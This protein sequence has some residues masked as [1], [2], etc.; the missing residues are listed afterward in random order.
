M[1]KKVSGEKVIKDIR[2]RTPTKY[3]SDSTSPENG[4]SCSHSGA[5]TFFT[6]SKYLFMIFRFKPVN[7]AIFVA[8]S[9]RVKY[10]K[11]CL[12]FNLKQL[13]YSIFGHRLLTPQTIIKQ[14]KGM[15]YGLRVWLAIPQA[16]PYTHEN[17]CP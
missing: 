15:I 12:L 4:D 6:K 10:F 8:S 14:H 3:S 16:T 1:N 7:C 13:A 2:R 11:I 9:S 5:I 17:F